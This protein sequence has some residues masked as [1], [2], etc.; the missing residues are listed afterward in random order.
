[1]NPVKA[2]EL[3]DKIEHIALKE[4]PLIKDPNIV[5]AQDNVERLSKEYD[6]DAMMIARMIVQIRKNGTYRDQEKRYGR[7]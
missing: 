7:K 1:M 4:R 2:K 6:K 5:C 3:N